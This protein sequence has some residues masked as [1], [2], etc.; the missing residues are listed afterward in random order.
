M[1]NKSGGYLVGRKNSK[2]YVH[3]DGSM[4]GYLVGRRHSQGG[5]KGTNQSTGQPIEVES[6]EIQISANAVKGND[7]HTFNGKQMSSR[8]VLSYLNVQGGG[9]AFEDGGKVENEIK[10]SNNVVKKGAGNPIIYKGGEIIL[11]RGAV[12]SDKKYNFNGKEMTTREIASAIN[13]KGGGVSFDKGGD[14]TKDDCG[15]SEDYKKGGMTDQEYQA[16]RLQQGIKKERNDHYDTLSKLNAGT[17][18]IDNAV[19]EIAEKEMSIDK[20]YPFSE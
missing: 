9:V 16:Y 7:V 14:V 2:I 12:S 20:N 4:G 15:C 13:V 18:T 11:T 8:Q 17:I 5:I 19:R 6:G 1:E 10:D 3:N